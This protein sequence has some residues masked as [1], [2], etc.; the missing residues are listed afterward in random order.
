[1]IEQV[2]CVENSGIVAIL[3]LIMLGLLATSI[4]Y[5]KAYHKVVRKEL[6]EKWRIENERNNMAELYSLQ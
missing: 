4:H 2:G 1:M 5:Q 3:I 6:N